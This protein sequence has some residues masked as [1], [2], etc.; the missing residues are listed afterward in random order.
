MSSAN[1]GDAPSS[2]VVPY[3]EESDQVTESESEEESEEANFDTDSGK[4]VPYSVIHGDDTSREEV[5]PP[6]PSPPRTASK[7]VRPPKKR[8]LSSPNLEPL[9]KK[10]CPPSQ[11][12][13]A[14]TSHPVMPREE[15]FMEQI[16]PPNI[17]ST[18]PQQDPETQLSQSTTEDSDVVMEALDDHLVQLQGVVNLTDTA[19][20]RLHRRV[21]TGETRL[22]IVEHEVIAAEQRNERAGEQLDSFAAL[23]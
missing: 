2:P 4:T 3:E 20:R 21:A 8:A 6:T 17:G 14:E 9:P 18:K 23:T 7:T 11:R 1:S 13:I 22:T 12:E 16:D 5:K 10:H 15:G 19:L